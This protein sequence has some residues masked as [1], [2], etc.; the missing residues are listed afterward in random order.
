MQWCLSACLPVYLSIYPSIHP[1][2]SIHLPCTDT[3]L[4]FRNWNF[5]SS[6]SVNTADYKH[7]TK[8]STSLWRVSLAVSPQ[9]VF[10]QAATDKNLRPG[11]QWSTNARVHHR[12]IYLCLSI[13]L[14]IS[15]CIYLSL[16]VSIY[17]SI[18]VSI[19]LSIYLSMYLS[20]Y[21]I[22]LSIYQCNVAWGS[23]I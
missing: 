7:M 15:L 13:D 10:F 22:Y 23:V 21:L 6:Y 9:C 1:S 20:I 3:I 2:E 11:W 5:N 18:D 14:S 19:Y 17:A 4:I 12:P 16:H 8:S